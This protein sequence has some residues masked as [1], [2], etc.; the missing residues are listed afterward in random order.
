MTTSQGTGAQ[1]GPGNTATTG[2]PLQAATYMAGTM[3]VDPAACCTPAIGAG[4]LRAFTE[5]T[6]TWG[7]RG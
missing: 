7:M 6:D 3:I 2:G 4:S 5:R 1:T